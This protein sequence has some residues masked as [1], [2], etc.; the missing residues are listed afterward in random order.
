MV[1][2]GLHVTKIYPKVPFLLFLKL[3]LV[4]DDNSPGIGEKIVESGEEGLCGSLL[5]TLGLTSSL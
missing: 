3:V 1:D 2:L 4:D 5:M